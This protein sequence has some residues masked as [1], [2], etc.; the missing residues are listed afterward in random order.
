MNKNQQESL[1]NNSANF[2]DKAAFIIGFSALIL[3]FYPYKEFAQKIMVKIFNW[4]ISIY[5]L[6]GVFLLIL[7]LTT[8]I[9]GLN[10]IRYDFPSILKIKCLNYIELLAHIMYMI[11]F[12]F[13]ILVMLLV[14]ISSLTKFLPDSNQW[15]LLTISNIAT[16]II[17]TA[18]LYIGIRTYKN[19]E[20]DLI[21]ELLEE[22]IKFSENTDF[23]KGSDH[24]TILN[25][26]ESIILNMESLLIPHIGI[27]IKKLSSFRVVELASNK[28]L[29]S[30]QEVKIIKEL[31][32]IRNQI[33]HGQLPEG[34]SVNLIILIEAQQILKHLKRKN[35]ILNSL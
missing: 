6:I 34:A 20:A 12:T 8:Y 29:I 1:I 23:S 22:Q 9:Y 3:A 35:K 18:S 5:N 21:K 17:T 7:F 16:T 33:A 4:D 25:L 26:Y 27:S 13:P 28:K 2:S 30:P 15:I 14:L 10:Y 19:K 11:A 31:R 24:L 32:K